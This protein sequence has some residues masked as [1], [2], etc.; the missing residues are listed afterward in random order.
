MKENY[1]AFYNELKRILDNSDYFNDV[2]FVKVDAFDDLLKEL[3]TR[4][5]NPAQYKEEIERKINSMN[6]REL[7]EFI[8]KFTYD[9]LF[10][11]NNISQDLQYYFAKYYSDYKEKF[12]K[13]LPKYRE[14]VKKYVI[15]RFEPDNSYRY[16]SNIKMIEKLC[17][18]KDIIE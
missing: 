10:Y 1:Y 15:S 2:E 4:I 6:D 9:R 16:D 14:E 18:K 11:F 7:T 8:W 12:E 5:N 3:K 17:G 13:L